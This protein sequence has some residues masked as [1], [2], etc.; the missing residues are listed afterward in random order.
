M[1]DAVRYTTDAMHRHRVERIAVVSAMGVGDSLAVVPFY[2][3]WL[4]KH[5]NLGKTYADHNLAD[6]EIRTTQ[7]AWTLVRAAGPSNSD[8]PKTLHTT[9]AGLGEKPGLLVSRRGGPV[10]RGRRSGWRLG[11]S[12]TNHLGEITRLGEQ[13]N[14]YRTI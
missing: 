3:R 6:A 5:T 14:A 12:G 10:R 4:I 13:D 1:A 9:E 8:K 2:L 7:T 11:R